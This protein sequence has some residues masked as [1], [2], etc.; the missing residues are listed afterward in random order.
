MELIAMQ[1]KSKMKKNFC[2]TLTNPK[3][4]LITIAKTGTCV[5]K[6]GKFDSNSQPC[7]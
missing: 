7:Q 5:K 2:S 3:S 4:S 6:V 1:V